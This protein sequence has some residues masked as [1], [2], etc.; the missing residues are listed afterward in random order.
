MN[1]NMKHEVVCETKKVFHERQNQRHP[2]NDDDD[3]DDDPS[4][5]KVGDHDDGNGE[6]W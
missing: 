6:G 3:D 2:G 1:P 4:S 5:L